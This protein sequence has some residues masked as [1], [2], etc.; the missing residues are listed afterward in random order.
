MRRVAILLRYERRGLPASHRR[1][2][3]TKQNET[4]ARSACTHLKGRLHV[5]LHGQHCAGHANSLLWMRQERGAQHRPQGTMLSEACHSKG[6]AE[7]SVKHAAARG[8]LF[9]GGS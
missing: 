7:P 8:R 9:Y 2:A 3:V 6:M 4:L 5:L 1:G